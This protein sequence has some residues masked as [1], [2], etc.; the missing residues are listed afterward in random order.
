MQSR[1][2]RGLVGLALAVLL[3]SS[4]GDRVDPAHPSTASAPRPTA[5][6]EYAPG[7]TVDLYLPARTGPVPLVVMVPGGGWA[8]ADPAGFAGLA[9][10]L[11]RS[12]VAA[13]P[14]RVRAAQDHVVYPVPVEDVLC[15]VAGAVQG[16]RARGLVP[17]PVVVLGHSSG[18]QLAALAVLAVRDFSPTCRAPAVAPDA[19]VGLSGPYDISRVPDLAARLVGGT[20]ASDPD[21]WARANPVERAG[22]RPQ[23]PVLLLHGAADES[24]PVAFT[25]QFGD[26]LTRAGHPTTVDVVPSADH[27]EIYQPGAAGD[28]IVRWLR[29][30]PVMPSPAG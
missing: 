12:G 16:V 8:T 14:A 19:L 28:R 15:A 25:L 21:A 6:V 26:A 23:V 10:A 13:A 1:G 17:Q 20:P 18:A 22:L 11:A 9:G 2:R 29:Q 5:T 4:C 3:V 27:A 7:L 30:L 24:V